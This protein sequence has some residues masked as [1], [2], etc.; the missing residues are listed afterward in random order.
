VSSNLLYESIH[1]EHV[2]QTGGCLAAWLALK[3]G[4]A[5]A[6]AG[7]APGEAGRA[8]AKAVATPRPLEPL[9]ENESRAELGTWPPISSPARSID[10]RA[11]VEPSPTAPSRVG[12]GRCSP[13]RRAEPRAGG[14]GS[15]GRVMSVDSG[16][17]AGRRRRKAPAASACLPCRVKTRRPRIR[18]VAR[19]LLFGRKKIE[20]VCCVIGG[21]G[22]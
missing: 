7:G 10:A 21:S 8:A 17:P 1:D 13:T 9:P 16:S 22:G 14:V 19:G 15:G 3:D 6:Q 18:G 2:P 20:P 4:R 5:Q 12:G 11:A